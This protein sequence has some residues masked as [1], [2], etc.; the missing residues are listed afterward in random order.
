[1]SYS[2]FLVKPKRFSTGENSG[3]LEGV[4]SI[5]AWLSCIMRIMYVDLWAHKLSN[6]N[7][8]FLFGY[9]CFSF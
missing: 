1:M 3:V 7:S 4:S 2:F 6:T 9:F 8:K 5:E